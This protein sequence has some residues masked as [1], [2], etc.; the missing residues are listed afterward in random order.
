MRKLLLSA[1]LTAAVLLAGCSAPAP[2][3]VQTEGSQSQDSLTGEQQS[4]APTENSAG[5]TS[6]GSTN[7]WVPEEIEQDAV[8]IQL[9]GTSATTQAPGVLIGEGEIEITEP[10]SYALSGDFHGRISITAPGQVTLVLNEAS[11][12]NPVGE[13]LSFGT[14]GVHVFLAPGADAALN[15]NPSI[16]AGG[17]VYL[18]GAGYLKSRGQI[19]AAGDLVFASGTVQATS[20][21][22]A[23]KAGGELAF[24]GGAVSATSDSVALRSSGDVLLSDGS[25]NIQS[26]KDGVICEGS[27][28]MRGGS[29]SVQAGDGSAKGNSSAQGVA[30]GKDLTIE[31]GAADVDAAGHALV[32][33]RTL[34]V[35]GGDLL[36]ASGRNGLRSAGDLQIS[37]GTVTV[38]ESEEGMEAANLTISGGEVAVRA[39]D[40]G[41]NGSA[42]HGA[43]SVEIA[44][45]Q[46]VIDAEGDGIDSN[47]ALTVSGGETTIFGPSAPKNGALDADG[48]LRL[49]GG[50][51]I[52]MS[53]GE[54]ERT[55]DTGEQAWI[56]ADLAGDAGTA[57]AILAADSPIAT[58]T[59]TKP[60][61]FIFFTGPQLKKDSE[62]TIQSGSESALVRAV[63]GASKPAAG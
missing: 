45:G 59:A 1:C 15:G 19:A 44:G 2:A 54:M 3:P 49:S 7:H 42:K 29:L 61:T 31:A 43:V 14:E 28:T 36:A 52:A 17:D 60:F 13:T 38:S 40:D 21:D 4:E 34:T 9:A 62:Y 22:T 23:I 48:E 32:A 50:T 57:V 58:V 35:S 27:F 11:V 12:T 20:E 26:G 37:G 25:L 16:L 5:A 55:P 56:Q 53:A 18:D 63:T 39:R 46:V 10:G 51:L 6:S 47:G 8:L 30:A 33:A 24:V 41:L